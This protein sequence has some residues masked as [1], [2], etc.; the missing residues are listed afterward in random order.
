MSTPNPPQI[1]GPQL[2]ELQ[3]L[4]TLLHLFHHRNRNQHRHSI[5]YRHFYTFR[6]QLDRL[7][8]DQQKIHEVPTTNLARAK[9]KTQDPIIIATTQKR[10]DF[11]RDVTVAKWQHSFS[12]LIADGRFSVL[13]LVLMGVLAEVCKVVG[14][15]AELEEMGQVEVERA[16]EEFGREAWG[17]DEGG[18]D[19]GEIV[20]RADDMAVAASHKPTTTASFETDTKQTV[21]VENEATKRKPDNTPRSTKKKRK[22]TGNAIDDIFG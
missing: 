3:E 14:I 10:L 13:G 9:K 2:Q 15:T 5:W 22:K 12:Q 16:L 19:V 17:M 21:A 7:V 8:S 1:S 18:E 6:K 20:R 4:T 11:W